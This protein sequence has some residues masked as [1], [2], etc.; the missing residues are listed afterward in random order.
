MEEF[1]AMLIDYISAWG[2]TAILIGMA[3]ESACL[4]VPSEII[5]GFAGYLVYLG[6]L[7]FTMAA[8]AGIAG[9]LTGSV[10]AYAIGYYGGRPFVDKYGK[11]VFLSGRHVV[12]AQRWF[13][14]YGIKATFYSRLLPV[15]R[16]FISLPAGFARVNFFQF[17][18]YTLLGSVPWTILLIYAGMMLGEQWQ[19]LHAVGHRLSLGVVLIMAVLV[20]YYVRKRH[21]H[22][23][24]GE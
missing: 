19:I 3:M 14:R 16:T 9:G 17:V 20:L 18:I 7:D 1:F 6:R 8:A 5:F 11:Y 12:A 22:L 4:P 23:K 15:V 2:Y 10:M 21:K 24:E 13:D